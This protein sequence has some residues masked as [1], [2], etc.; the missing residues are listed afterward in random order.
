M[1][2]LYNKLEEVKLSVKEIVES[3][4]MTSKIIIK[5][6]YNSR[7]SRVIASAKREYDNLFILQ[8]GD[9]FLNDLSNSVKYKVLQHEIAHMYDELYYRK[10]SV[11]DKKFKNLCWTLYGDRNIGQATIKGW[12]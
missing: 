8:V 11:H 4:D 2:N 12:E 6:Q 7:Y 5:C 9:L 3:I 10:H 1:N